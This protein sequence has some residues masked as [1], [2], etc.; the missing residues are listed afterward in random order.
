[1]L[2][3]ENYL[4][5]PTLFFHG[6]SGNYFTFNGMINRFEKLGL[7]K[8][9]CLILVT[10]NGKL[11]FKGKPQSLMQVVFLN[12]KVDVDHQVKWIWKI[13]NHLKYKFNILNVNVIAHSMGCISILKYLNQF[14]YTSLNS[15][16]EKVVTLG[17]PFND[18]I[19]GENTPY[20]EEHPLTKNGPIDM[21]ALYHWMQQHRINL[22]LEIKFLNIAGNLQN[23]S[24]SDGQVSLDSAR[25]LRYLMRDAAK[26]YHEFILKGDEASH[27]GLHENDEVDQRIK[28]FLIKN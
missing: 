12:N 4:Q 27:S 20:I 14:G 17:A 22:P 3:N 23:G 9:K 2:K 15:K 5:T 16:V 25:S 21:T 18:E 10:S 19:I 6:Y 24:L 8:N 26:Q 11:I 28:R 13:L 7:G 1:M